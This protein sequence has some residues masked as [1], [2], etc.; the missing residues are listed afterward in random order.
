MVNEIQLTTP[1]MS[2]A[3]EIL[4]IIAARQYTYQE[5]PVTIA[6]TDYSRSKG[7]SVINAINIAFDTL[8]RKV[9]R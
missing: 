4:E 7:Q 6:Y 5:V 9:L 3:S 8:L 2:H 1:D